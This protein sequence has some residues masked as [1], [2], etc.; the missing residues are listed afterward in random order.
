LTLTY[1]FYNSISG[2]RVYDAKDLSS[3]FDG[4]INDGIFMSIGDYFRVTASTGMDVVV[5]TGRS[6]FNSSWTLN[7]A[8]IVLTVDPAELVLNRI[9]VVVIEVNAAEEVR[10]NSIKIVKGTPA[11]NPVAPALTNTELIHQYPL[12]HI[13]IG[14][15]VSEIIT[16]NITNKIG[17]ASTPFITGILQT[18]NTEA[19]LS[20]WGSE[21]NAQMAAWTAA[22][23]AWFNTNT[24]EWT[25]DFNLWF[26]EIQGLLG[27]EPAG[28]LAQAIYD[29]RYATMPHHFMDGPTEFR[30]GLSVVDGV[31]MFNYEE[32][33]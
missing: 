10:A 5:G 4:I 9:D 24:L 19:L 27:A 1:G 21:F 17:T 14:A 32:V 2:D 11:T 28:V 26:A 15:G 8:P 30:W 6:W 16:A 12:A 23:N 3:L 18:I 25:G 31:V 33:V 22:F 7:D 29:H 20:Q 13:Y